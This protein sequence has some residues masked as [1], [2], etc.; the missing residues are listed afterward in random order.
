MPAADSKSGPPCAD[1]NAGAFSNT[2]WSVVLSA[3]DPRDSTEAMSS[4]ETLCR[5]YWL[6]LYSFVRRQ[7]ESPHDALESC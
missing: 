3:A 7:G 4:L 6:P 1:S 2:H 5:A